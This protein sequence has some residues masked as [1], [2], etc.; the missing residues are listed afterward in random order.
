MLSEEELTA[1]KQRHAASTPG[2][3]TTG[4][5]YFDVVSTNGAIICDSGDWG[6]LISEG[7]KEFIAN[8][9]QDI[10]K[11]LHDVG[12][13]RPR[14]EKFLNLTIARGGQVSLWDDELTARIA[15]PSETYVKLYLN[16][17]QI[18]LIKAAEKDAK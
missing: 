4:D 7:D 3:W 6:G 10:P 12:L 1:I 18:G 9:H 16:N 2:T 14:Q 13:F 15:A 11:L 8:A 17:W 5:P